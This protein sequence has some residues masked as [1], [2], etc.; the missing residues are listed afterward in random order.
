MD[1]LLSLSPKAKEKLASVQVLNKSVAYMD[2]VLS[3]DDTKWV[4][5]MK[6][7]ISRYLKEGTDGQFFYRMV[8]T[9]LSRDKNW[10]RWKL[11]NC[12]AI[13]MPAVSPETYAEAMKA[14][15]TSATNKRLR[16]QALGSLQLDFLNEGDDETAMQKLKSEERY[17]LPEL[18]SLKRKIQEDDLEIDMPLNEQSKSAAIEGKASKTWKALRIASRSRLALFDKIDSY[19]KINVLFED[20]AKKEE[21]TNGDAAE[22]TEVEAEVV[23]DAASKTATKATTETATGTTETETEENGKIPHE[24]GVSTIPTVATAGAS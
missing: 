15:R 10:V 4:E 17:R 2:Q 5:G 19:E 13:E 22:E 11:E 12:T 24:N 21:E 1:F 20:P 23:T 16:P 3:E 8:E 14:A 7:T 9:V 18:A 6:M